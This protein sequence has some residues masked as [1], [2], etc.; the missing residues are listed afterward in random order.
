MSC[1]PVLGEASARRLEN[2]RTHELSRWHWMLK[3]AVFGEPGDSGAPVWMQRSGKAV[4]VVV[5]GGLA[6]QPFLR[7]P[8]APAGEVAGVLA[9]PDMS[10]PS[11]PLHVQVGG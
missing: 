5:G 7:P 8:N 2:P 10:P 6:I 9:D 1:G 11:R 3:A 4:G